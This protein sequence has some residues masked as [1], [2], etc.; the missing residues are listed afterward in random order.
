MHT[1]TVADYT[2]RIVTPGGTNESELYGIVY[3][4]AHREEECRPRNG[5]GSEGAVGAL[6]ALVQTRCFG[7]M[8]G[9][10]VLSAYG[11]AVKRMFD[12]DGR[13]CVDL[14]R[15]EGF[16]ACLFSDYIPQWVVGA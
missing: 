15:N 3:I 14:L 5:W 1:K 10:V 12:R 4:A 11:A 13:R 9:W 8:V 16:E 7:G 6:R 2:V